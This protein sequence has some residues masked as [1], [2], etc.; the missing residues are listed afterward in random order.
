MKM[1][2]LGALDEPYAST[3]PQLPV[4]A[5]LACRRVESSVA[6]SVVNETAGGEGGGGEGGGE[7]GGG[8]GG[9]EGGGDCVSTSNATS[10]MPGQAAP[11]ARMLL[12]RRYRVEREVLRVILTSALGFAV[13]TKF[14][15]VVNEVPSLL[16]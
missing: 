6:T 1:P 2:T 13:T 14:S 4:S 16:V 15:T 10:K 8:E 7:G 12:N 9:G 5:G 11:D 3:L